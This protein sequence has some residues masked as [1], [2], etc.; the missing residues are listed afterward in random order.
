MQNTALTP[1]WILRGLPADN[2]WPNVGDPK[3]ASGRSRLVR[4]KRLKASA[5]SWTRTEPH[6]TYLITARLTLPYP[7][8]VRMLRPALP[9]EPNDGVENADVLYHRSAVG[10]SS[11]ASP[12]TFGRS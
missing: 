9:N 6:G 8:P 11:V 7:G 3:N 2:T 10:E 4:L 5:R 12:A 1:N